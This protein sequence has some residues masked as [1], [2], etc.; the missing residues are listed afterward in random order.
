MFFRPIVEKE[1]E[2]DHGG[3]ELCMDIRGD[4]G[5]PD[6]AARRGVIFAESHGDGNQVRNESGRSS[7]PAQF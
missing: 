3:G 4:P 7:P 2:E 1:E 6:D 5:F